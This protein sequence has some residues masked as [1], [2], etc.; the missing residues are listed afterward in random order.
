MR[1]MGIE[2]VYCKTPARS[3]SHI[4]FSFGRFWINGAGARPRA[5]TFAFAPPATFTF[6]VFVASVPGPENQ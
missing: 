6:T 1:V 3:N 2:A 4:E 5:T